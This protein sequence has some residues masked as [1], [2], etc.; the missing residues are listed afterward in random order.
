MRVEV[1]GSKGRRERDAETGM[2]RSSGAAGMGWMMVMVSTPA[3][4]SGGYENADRSRWS[5]GTESGE[6][7]EGSG[8]TDL[9]SAADKECSN[10]YTEPRGRAQVL[11]TS[12]WRGGQRREGRL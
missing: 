3:N 9:N 12:G 4:A 5:M 2:S 6:G 1:G 10:S 11:G 8:Q 7:A